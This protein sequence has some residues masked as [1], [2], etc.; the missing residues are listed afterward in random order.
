MLVVEVTTIVPL[1]GALFSDWEGKK[2]AVPLFPFF[3]HAVPFQFC[4]MAAVSY[5]AV[6]LLMNTTTRAKC[7]KTFYFRKVCNKLPCLSWQAFPAKPTVCEHGRSLPFQVL[8]SKVGSCPHPQAWD[9]AG[10]PFQ[11]QTIKLITKI[12]KVRT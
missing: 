7:Y 8:H 2:R 1:S 12:H 10:K 4:G 6:S 3:K 11:G 5:Y 9:C